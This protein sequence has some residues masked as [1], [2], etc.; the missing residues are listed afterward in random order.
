[1]LNRNL[2]GLKEV[3]D[4]IES[5][6]PS[7]NIGLRSLKNIGVWLCVYALT[8][9]N[10]QNKLISELAVKANLKQKADYV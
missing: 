9:E 3:F 4:R 7:Q 6:E 8:N 1:M 5:Y 2:N 10:D